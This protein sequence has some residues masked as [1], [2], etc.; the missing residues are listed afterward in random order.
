MDQVIAVAG[1]A[2]T[3]PFQIPGEAVMPGIS[4]TSGPLPRTVTLI[5]LELKGAPAAAA[6]PGSAQSAPSARQVR[7]NALRLIDGSLCRDG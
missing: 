2:A 3:V 4:T 5:R 6:W 7:R 1:T